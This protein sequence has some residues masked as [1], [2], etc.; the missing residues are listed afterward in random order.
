LDPADDQP[1]IGHQTEK[2]LEMNLDSESEEEADEFPPEP[3]EEPEII[4]PITK[5]SRDEPD[6]PLRLEDEVGE[7]L[8]PGPGEEPDARSGN[9]EWLGS[10]NG[11][12]RTSL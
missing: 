7:D 3:D 12:V 8:P 10:N 9:A 6:I 2:I 5:E 11:N 4:E 1:K